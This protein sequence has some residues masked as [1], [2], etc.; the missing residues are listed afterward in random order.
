MTSPHVFFIISMK[1]IKQIIEGPVTAFSGS[2]M[3]R[4]MISEQIKARWGES[5]LKNYDPFHNARTFQS[6]LKLGFKVRKGEK[7]L[8]SITFVETKDSEGI[9]KRYRR[10]VFIFY[11]RQVEKI[12][13][14]KSYE[15]NNND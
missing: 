4:A 11:Y 9:L 3:S 12:G 5:E 2:E 1:S 13:S 10:P 15:K 8:R 14:Q 6:W 7:A